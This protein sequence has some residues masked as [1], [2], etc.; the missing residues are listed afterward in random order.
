MLSVLAY[1]RDEG[2]EKTATQMMIDLGIKKTSLMAYLTLLKEY[3]FVDSKEA[4][5]KDGKKHVGR[6]ESVFFYAG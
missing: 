3:D 2:N 5:R 4:P 1:L 6:Q